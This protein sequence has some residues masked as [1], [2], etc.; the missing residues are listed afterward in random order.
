MS[1]TSALRT[2]E[3]KR[4]FWLDEDIQELPPLVRFAFMG[5]WAIADREGRFEDNPRRIK[6]LLFPGDDIDIEN[7][8]T[9]LAAGRFLVRY[10]IGGKKYCE[11]RNFARHQRPHPHERKSVMPP[12]SAG[13]HDMS[14]NVIECQAGPSGPSGSS[15]PSVTPAN[16]FPERPAR[17][18][19]QAPSSGLAGENPDPKPEFSL[20]TR[21]ALEWVLNHLGSRQQAIDDGLAEDPALAVAIA[22]CGGWAALNDRLHGNEKQIK[23]ALDG[24]AVAFGKACGNR[25]NTARGS[26]DAPGRS[27]P[28]NKAA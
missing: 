23:R 4:T 26:P 20:E 5:L 1:N 22:K 3:T 27:P 21:K 16:G 9:S 24:L 7:V 10:H 2:R 14:C 15:E 13:C 6:R 12:P 17:A 11:I 18:Y 8:I 19:R 28:G 25:A